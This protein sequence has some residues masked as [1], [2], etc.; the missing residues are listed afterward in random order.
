MGR[1]FLV[2]TSAAAAAVPHSAYTT[3]VAGTP[4]CNSS[5]AAGERIQS[6]SSK[7][8]C[9]WFF[10][11]SLFTVFLCLQLE[12]T[13]LERSP[14]AHRTV[15]TSS[16]RIN[17]LL[18]PAPAKATAASKCFCL[19]P[20]GRGHR[21]PPHLEHIEHSDQPSPL[22][23][24][25]VLL[26]FSCWSWRAHGRQSNLRQRGEPCFCVVLPPAWPFLLALSLSDAGMSAAEQSFVFSAEPSAAPLAVSFPRC[27]SVCGLVFLVSLLLLG[28]PCVVGQGR[29]AP[30]IDVSLPNIRGFR[31]CQSPFG[32]SASSRRKLHQNRSAH[33]SCPPLELPSLFGA[34]PEVQQR[35]ERDVTHWPLKGQVV[36]WRISQGNVGLLHWSECG[37]CGRCFLVA[38]LSTAVKDDSNKEVSRSCIPPAS[39]ATCGSPGSDGAAGHAGTPVQ[40]V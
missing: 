15:S 24:A 6:S 30:N 35:L 28:A 31:F 19:S 33:A 23:C 4:T 5:A 20:V 34:L 25:Q 27:S 11:F 3:F 7:I 16:T 38:C 40:L 37:A 13:L 22:A 9:P 32:M 14:V 21:G 10:L 26:P 2:S 18:W 29:A 8:F 1:I 12:A 36:V 17:R 39:V